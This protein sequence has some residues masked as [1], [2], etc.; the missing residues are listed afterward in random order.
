MINHWNRGVASFLKL[1]KPKRVR[2]YNDLK[3]GGKIK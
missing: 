1:D 3:N 2:I